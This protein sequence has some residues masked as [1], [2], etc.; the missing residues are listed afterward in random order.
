MNFNNY[1]LT[2]DIHTNRP[3]IWTIEVRRDDCT[4]TTSK[5]ELKEMS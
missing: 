3:T 5:M 2:E 4:E 1:L